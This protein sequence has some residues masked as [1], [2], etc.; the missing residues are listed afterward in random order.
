MV[1]RAA[2]DPAPMGQWANHGGVVG[3]P[4]LSIIGK[5]EVL[6]P[7]MGG[8]Q[9][10]LARLG[11][12]GGLPCVGIEAAAACPSGCRIWPG[13][14]LR[15]A[16]LQLAASHGRGRA[17]LG[18]DGHGRLPLAV[19]VVV[20]AADASTPMVAARVGVGFDVAAGLLRTGH[21]CGCLGV[22]STASTWWS[23]L[24]LALA[25]G[26]RQLVGPGCGWSALW[27][28]AAVLVGIMWEWRL[29]HGF[30]AKAQ[31]GFARQMTMTPRAPHTSWEA[32]LLRLV[33]LPDSRESP[34]LEDS[35]SSG[36]GT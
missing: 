16:L 27:G 1:R 19:A 7:H 13:L 8:G 10:D 35:K 32:S 14:G 33:L 3:A 6:C 2:L 28:G 30:W 5:V 26:W 11:A 21:F 29:L 20:A 36:G 31:L 24:P 12:A 25:C 23:P 18:Q 4:L 15:R 17:W 34:V 22:V 9:L